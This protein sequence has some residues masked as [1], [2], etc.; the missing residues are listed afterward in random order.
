LAACS[1]RT[2]LL[3]YG[4]QLEGSNLSLIF[5]ELDRPLAEALKPSLDLVWGEGCRCWPAPRAPALTV[6]IV[7]EAVVGVSWSPDAPD[8]LRIA[9]PLTDRAGSL[10][11]WSLIWRAGGPAAGRAVV[12]QALGGCNPS[13]RRTPPSW[14]GALGDW[15]TGVSWAT[16]GAWFQF[17]GESGRKPTAIQAVGMLARVVQ[18]DS[19]S[20][21]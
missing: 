14:V 13:Q 12:R 3:G 6:R 17:R 18:P 10:C 5:A 19:K 11:R 4:S 9:S 20:A 7:R 15:L 16:A 1:R 8:E 2:Y 21:C